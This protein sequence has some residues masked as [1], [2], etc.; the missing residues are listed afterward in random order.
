MNMKLGIKNFLLVGV[1]ATLFILGA[2]V[3]V[4]KYPVKGLSEV[5]TAV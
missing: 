4:S 5:I 2:K 3:I 1:M